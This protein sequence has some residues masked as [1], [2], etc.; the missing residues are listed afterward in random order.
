M[1]FVSGG[2]LFRHIVKRKRFTEDETR[3]FGYQIALA[4]GHLHSQ[5]IIYR[6]LKPENVLMGEDG[7]LYLADFGLAKTI[8]PKKELALSFCGT[9]EYLSPEMINE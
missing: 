8:D 3:F 7:F 4:I 2:E 1:N 9:A 6:D 5:N